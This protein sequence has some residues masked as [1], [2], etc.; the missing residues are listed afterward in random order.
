[1]QELAQSGCRLFRQAGL[2]QRPIHQENPAVARPLVDGERRMPH[3]QPGMPAF[4]NVPGRPAE[5]KNEKVRQPLLRAR[6]I[7]RRIHRPQDLILWHL[8][9]ESASQTAKAFFP[10]DEVE[11]FFHGSFPNH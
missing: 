2:L 8:A 11:L 3:P 1:V 10:D 6:Q 5:S 4:L 7:L 9:I